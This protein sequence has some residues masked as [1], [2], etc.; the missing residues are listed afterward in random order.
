MDDLAQIEDCYKKYINNINDWIPEGISDV[1]LYTL[2]QLDLLD[3]T[4]KS[5]KESALTRYFHVIETSEK[6]TLI[7]EQF[8]IWIVPEKREHSAMTYTLIA[9]NHPIQP[10]LEVAFA[11][12]GI[13]NSSRLVLRV[14]EKYLQEIED[15]EETLHKF[16]S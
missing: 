9:L 12:T 4:R 8:I 14:L 5:P 3:L 10:H 16:A 13:Y 7:N 11:S 6:I 2:Q 15:T 1:N